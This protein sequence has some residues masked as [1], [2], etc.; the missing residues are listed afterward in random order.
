MSK[1]NDTQALIEEADKS[2]IA[3]VEMG[4]NKSTIANVEFPYPIKIDIYHAIRIPDIKNFP[5]EDFFKV[6]FTH[7]I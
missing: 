7:H 6:P 5:V 4:K 3:N 1:G 2:T